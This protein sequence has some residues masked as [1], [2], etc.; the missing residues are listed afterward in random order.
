MESTSSYFAGI[1]SKGKAIEEY[2]NGKL[3]KLYLMALR[4][5]GAADDRNMVYVPIGIA[6]IKD[7]YDNVVEDLL[8][9]NKVESYNCDL[10]YRGNSVIPC[11]I[12]IVASKDGREVFKEAIN[13]W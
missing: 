2:N 7:S 13:V 12:I 4:F 1:D 10:K 6:K 5:G 3:E 8:K 9:Q 11:E